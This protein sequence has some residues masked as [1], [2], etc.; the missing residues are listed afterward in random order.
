MVEPQRNSRSGDGQ[1]FTLE[2][3]IMDVLCVLAENACEVV[4]RDTLIEQICKIEHGGDES[5]TRAISIP[6]RRFA[7]AGLHVDISLREGDFDAG[8]SERLVDCR[9]QLMANAI[10]L[11]RI[12]YEDPHFEIE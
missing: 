11:A 10:S 6:T 5:L 8:L 7:L 12:G 4:S 3:R 1:S 9:V 2:P